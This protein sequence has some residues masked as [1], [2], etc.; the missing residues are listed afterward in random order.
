L[1]Q[2]LDHA[3]RFVLVV[4]VCVVGCVVRVKIDTPWYPHAARGAFGS[5][6][7]SYMALPEI[8]KYIH[9]RR[10]PDIAQGLTS[11]KRDRSSRTHETSQS[12]IAVVIQ[13]A[14][15]LSSLGDRIDIASFRHV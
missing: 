10:K 14:L 4:S 5:R 12:R 15:S 2:K 9:F 11:L 6:V 3:G 1:L 13:A 8:S 7:M